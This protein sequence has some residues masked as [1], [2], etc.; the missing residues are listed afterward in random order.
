MRAAAMSL[1]AAAS[2]FVVFLLSVSVVQ[3]QDGWAVTYTPTEICALR[4]ST[5]DMRCTYTYPSSM[6]G[7]KTTV[8]EASWFVKM[9]RNEPV[10]VE[11]DPQ[12][13]GRVDAQCGDSNCTLRITDLR[14]SDSAEYKFRF[15]L[16]Q[17]KRHIGSPGVTLS[18]TAHLDVQVKVSRSGV[19]QSS[20]WAELK[21]HSRCPPPKRLHYI[22]Y[23]N[24][25]K[26]EGQTSHLYSV[27]SGPADNFS[28]AVEGYE[29]F[30]SP[31]VSRK[32]LMGPST[33]T[34][35]T[36]APELPS[37]SVSSSAET[38][39][40]TGSHNSTSHLTVAAAAGTIPVVLL[41]VIS[42]SVY[43]WIRKKR[44]SN[45][46]SE[47]EE[48]PDNREQ[49]EQGEL[50]YASIHFSNN[51]ADPTPLYSNHSPAGL[52]RHMEQQEVSEYAAV[53]F[54]SGSTAPRTRGQQTGQ[55][56]AAL[57]CTVNKS[58]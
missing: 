48:R 14:E 37:V 35:A 3:G 39:D 56:P 27:S 30:R 23:K 9:N 12:Y 10:D 4:G 42:L 40:T 5:V 22:W 36:K 33:T 47:A 50:Q 24:G 13:S 52:P 32:D 45:E 41:A 51:R 34:R 38:V 21:C 20:N 44:T 1:S 57:Y 54:N 17:H 26:I 19:S 28:C 29:A 25:Q 43:L 11:T 2:G 8:E 15:K 46:S 6:N 53:R 18:V 55:N 49:G 58:R 16:S 7:P 31:P